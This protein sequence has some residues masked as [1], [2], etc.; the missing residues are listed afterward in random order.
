MT[1]PA[2]ADI[3]LSLTIEVQGTII[4]NIQLLFQLLRV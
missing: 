3:Q 4:V 2:C 1:Y